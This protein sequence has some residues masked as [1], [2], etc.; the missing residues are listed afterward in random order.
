MAPNTTLQNIHQPTEK[1]LKLLKAG[2]FRIDW[3][4]LA[5]KKGDVFPED[6]SK[7]ISIGGELA[8]AMWYAEPEV[9]QRS[10]WTCPLGT[11]W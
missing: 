10:D 11:S 8:I 1:Y 5:I 7:T 3:P 2:S 9:K 4:L 6:L